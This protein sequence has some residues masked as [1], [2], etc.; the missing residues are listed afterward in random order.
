MTEK[1]YGVARIDDLESFPIPQQ[2]GLNWRPVRRH[3]GIRSFGVN[4]YSADEVGQ[5]L[6]EEHREKDG[7][8][9][10]YVVLSGRAKFTLD[11]DEHDAPAGTLIHCPPGTLREAFAAEPGT[12]VLGIG[13]KPGEA[14]QPSGWEWVFAG[15]S[16]LEQ[17]DEE[18]ARRE[19]R[20]GIETYPDDWQGYFNL[21]CVEARLGNN[22]EAL[23]QLERAAQLEPET[24]AKWS[25]ED[26]DLVSIRDEP[27]FLTITGQAQAAG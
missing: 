20:A 6:V 18:G 10:L 25:K 19:L 16:R 9:E 23:A 2:Q 14:Y 12:S 5:R 4:A 26:D 15:V 21:A 11:G 22:D 3:F 8:D 13:A 17:G 1:G 7:H 27:R 24:V